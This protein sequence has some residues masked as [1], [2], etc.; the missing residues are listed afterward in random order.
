MDVEVD[1]SKEICTKPYKN[2]YEGLK[3]KNESNKIFSILVAL[4]LVTNLNLK[5]KLLLTSLQSNIEEIWT[6]N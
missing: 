3:Q 4:S 2:G 5:V 6:L 1:I